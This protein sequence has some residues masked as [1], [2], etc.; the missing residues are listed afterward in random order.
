MSRYAAMFESARADGRAPVMAWSV[1]GDPTPEAWLDVV[2]AVVSAGASA[3]ELSLAFSDPSADGPV[4][5]DAYTRVLGK[6]DKHRTF[7][8]IKQ[9]RE[10]YPEL[11]IGLMTYANLVYTPSP[12]VFYAACAAADVDSVLVADVPVHEAGIFRGVAAAH[13]IEVVLI[14]PPNA[15]EAE[16]KAIAEQSQGFVYLVSRAGVTGTEREAQSPLASVIGTLKQYG[17]PPTILGFGISRAEHVRNAIA[18]GAD[19]V[20]IGSAFAKLVTDHVDDPAAL[21]T[22]SAALITELRSGAG[23]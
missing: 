23:L 6:V 15:R 7:A 16:L 14:A 4:N 12:K 2:D 18:A 21:A 3:L 9:V 17:G 5:Q 1:V 13:G 20:V 8:L 19:G 22:A 11:P 10:R